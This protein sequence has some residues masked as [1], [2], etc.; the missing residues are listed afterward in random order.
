MADVEPF[1]QFLKRTAAAQAEDFPQ[2][3]AAEFERIQKHILDYYKAVPASAVTSYR[4]E[5][6]QVID[7]IPFE[8][9]PAV[10]SAR[11]SGQDV[12]HSDHLIPMKRLTLDDLAHFGSLDNFFRK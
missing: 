11:A 7:R 4:N 1:D 10:I 8:C 5:S 3:A 6:G 2:L 12:A 9:Q